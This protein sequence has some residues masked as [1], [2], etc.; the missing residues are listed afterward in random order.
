MN[1][2]FAGGTGFSAQSGWRPR[3]THE[4]LH[5]YMNRIESH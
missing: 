5:V 1:R 2:L 4:S 3:S